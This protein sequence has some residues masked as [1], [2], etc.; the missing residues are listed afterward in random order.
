MVSAGFIV[1]LTLVGQ[2]LHG[3]FEFREGYYLPT[4]TQLL[5]QGLPKALAIL[6]GIGDTAFG[7][8]EFIQVCVDW[9]TAYCGEFAVTES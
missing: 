3:G 4:L 1:M 9:N 7:S 8:I 2:W 5:L 6:W